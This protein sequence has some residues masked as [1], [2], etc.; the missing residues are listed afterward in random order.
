MVDPGRVRRLLD[1]LRLE[2]QRL[3]ALAARPADDLLADDVAMAAV[4]FRFVIAIE[5]CVDAGQHVIASEGLRAP[6]TY[7][8]VFASLAEGGVIRADDVGTLRRMARFRNRLLHLYG[9]TDESEVVRILHH[10]LD[11]LDRFRE[12]IARFAVPDDDAGAG[13]RHDGGG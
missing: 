12:Q 10:H 6:D 2:T 9:D 13:V 11:D 4:Q 8:D 5:V 3:R 1:R 7:A